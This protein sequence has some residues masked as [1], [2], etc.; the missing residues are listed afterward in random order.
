MVAKSIVVVVSVT[1]SLRNLHGRAT[2]GA[3]VTLVGEYE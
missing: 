2:V 1:A 3:C